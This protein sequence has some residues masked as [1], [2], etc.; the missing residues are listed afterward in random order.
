[1]FPGVLAYQQTRTMAYDLRIEESES[2]PVADLYPRLWNER[3]C[4]PEQKAVSSS[5]E[6]GT[7]LQRGESGG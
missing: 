5:F 1:M 2:I 3:L 7:E 4:A 6:S